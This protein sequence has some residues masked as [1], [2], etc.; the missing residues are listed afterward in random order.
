MNVKTI[1]KAVSIPIIREFPFILCCLALMG[2][3]G[4]LSRIV[5]QC[6]Y[7]VNIGMPSNSVYFSFIFIW[8]F[9]IFLLT[10][11]INKPKWGW[12]KW[13]AFGGVFL[14][15]LIQDF[16]VQNFNSMISPTYLTLLAETNHN[17]ASDFLSQFVLSKA[18]MPT[19]KRAS[20]LLFVYLLLEVIWEKYVRGKETRDSLCIFTGTLII[21]LL[22]FG[23]LSCFAISSTLIK[24]KENIPE[25][26]VPSDPISRSIYSLIVFHGYGSYIEEAIR[27]TH[28]IP[29]FVSNIK[30]S[31]NI[32]LVIGESY[33]KW[34]ASLYG[35]ELET[36]PF[37]VQ[38]ERDG[39]LF[40]FQDAVST[41]NQTTTSMK[42][43]LCCNNLATGETWH[44]KPYLPALLRQSGFDVAFWDNQR[45]FSKNQTF[46]YTL[47]GFI[48]SPRIIELSYSQLNKKTFVYDEDLILDYAKN[49]HGN[50]P[51]Q[52]TIFHLMGQHF[53]PKNRYPDTPDNNYFK[54]TDILNNANYL[55]I[56]KKQLIAEY[57]NATR[58]NDKV[59][60][61]IIHLFEEGNSIVIY[62]S[63]HGDE[64]Y[65]FRDQIY[66]EQGPLIPGKLKYQYEIPFM[67]WVS[68]KY[69]QKNP[70]IIKAIN[71][72]TSKSFSS[73][74]LFHL[75]LHLAGI[76]SSPYQE[77]YDIIEPAYCSPKR[78]ID[79]K[80]D[81]DAIIE[82]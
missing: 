71:I 27:N 67:I 17:E 14:L 68:D 28:E 15:F 56:G 26:I 43:I 70:D 60:E 7:G 64:I 21:V 18:S 79:E 37:Q 47:N 36:T 12:L 77:E 72:A 62:L 13:G 39:H 80:Y 31:L 44:E 76:T 82:S 75:I 61:R 41:S 54:S 49:Y 11:L 8:V 30:D 59:F 9:F 53:V 69:K 4:I 65:D 23:G 57:D 29:P 55:D 1:S 2:V 63:D 81:F 38:E 78:V 45:D 74:C 58:Y 10:Y 24:E 42:N 46:S 52:F 25:N 3:K 66:R 48:Y 51:L 34:H 22:F 20:F 16:L 73:D 32:I 50:S 33:S 35:Y 40:A 19:L 6:I 5:Q